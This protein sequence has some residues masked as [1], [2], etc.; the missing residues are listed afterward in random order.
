MNFYKI[1]Y[2]NIE[3]EVKKVAEYILINDD[4]LDVYSTIIA[5]LIY[6]I[7]TEIESISKDL[8]IKEFNLNLNSKERSNLKFDY[9]CLE[10]L[11]KKFNICNKRIYFS[12]TYIALTTESFQPLFGAEKTK[13][14]ENKSK[15]IE[16]YHSLK[17]DRYKNIKNATIQN[18]INSLGAL[19]ILNIYYD[20]T[21][22]KPFES[23]FF[24][25][26]G[27]SIIDNFTRLEQIF[28]ND[29]SEYGNIDDII[30]IQMYSENTAKIILKSY[31]KAYEILM[32]EVIK[33]EKLMKKLE[34]NGINLDDDIVKVLMENDKHYEKKLLI[35]NQYIINQSR[36]HIYF[37]SEY[38]CI[39]DKKI[40][41]LDLSKKRIPYLIGKEN[42]Y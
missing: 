37:E 33:D 19:Y 40:Y 31:E 13:K 2:E 38:K 26:S 22:I 41:N 24:I 11:N 3:N 4:Q 1:T 12:K 14:S 17:H 23:Y 20:G 34:D 39:T 5:D 36:Q 18:M 25:P 27:I 10:Q 7:A 28:K 9:K 32:G 35:M 30:Y 15:W 16:S 8:Y 6:K 29:L 42:Q 21:T